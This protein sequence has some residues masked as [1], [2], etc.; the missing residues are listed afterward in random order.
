MCQG[1]Q[2][3]C[4]QLNQK[5]TLPK[6]ITKLVQTINSDTCNFLQKHSDTNSELQGDQLNFRLDINVFKI[7]VL[8]NRWELEHYT[9]TLW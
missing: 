4:M 6:S 9:L 1:P 8:N 2:N 7:M 5:Q 3:T